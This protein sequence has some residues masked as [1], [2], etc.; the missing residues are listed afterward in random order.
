LDYTQGSQLANA[1]RDV[2]KQRNRTRAVDES[3]RRLSLVAEGVKTCVVV[4]ADGLAIAA[5]PQ[6]ALNSSQS[7]PLNAAEVAAIS[8]RL[9]GLAESSLNRLAQGRMG[10]LLLEGEQG[11]LLSCPAGDVTLALLVEP[12]ASMGHVL[13]AA[14]KA[15]AE[16]GSILART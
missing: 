14:Q 3:L 6:E 5:Y 13:F 10:R 9:A 8:A 2:M 11:T 4:S 15:A 1:V 7:G 16:I 12:G